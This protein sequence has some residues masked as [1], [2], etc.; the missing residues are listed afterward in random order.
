[1]DSRVHPIDDEDD[2]STAA[3]ERRPTAR[4]DADSR[5]AATATAPRLPDAGSSPLRLRQ[6]VTGVLPPPDF[7]VF[8]S[9]GFPLRFG[10]F[11][12]ATYDLD[13][14]VIEFGTH[15]FDELDDP[16]PTNSPTPKVPS[17]GNE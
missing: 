9:G 5:P 11:P 3:T 8:Y 15:G 12:A 17:L 4:P 1:M 13:G 7:D 14:L 6:P 10:D 16:S 2:R